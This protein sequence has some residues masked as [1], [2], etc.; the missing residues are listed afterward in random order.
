MLPRISTR[1]KE[2]GGPKGKFWAPLSPRTIGTRLKRYGNSPLTILRRRVHLA[3][4]INYQIGRSGLK[5]G[6]GG[7][8][9]DYVAIHQF[10]AKAGR[11]RKMKIPAGPYMAFSDDDLEIVTEEIAAY[12]E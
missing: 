2:E 5:I 3:G 4:S 7:E 6:T 11:G 9:N 1:F 12:F 10:G 8:V